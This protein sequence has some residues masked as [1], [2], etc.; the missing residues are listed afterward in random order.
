LVKTPIK[1]A[2]NK[3]CPEDF[4]DPALLTTK[5][6]GKTF[7]PHKEHE[8]PGEFGKVIFAERIVRPQAGIIDFSGFDPLL[9]RI[10][11]AI[12]DHT[13]RKGAAPMP[14]S[15]IPASP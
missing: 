7:N 9:T 12:D 11:A 2:D 8:A 6:D 14:A 15:L 5:I 1:G 13:K 3:S 4:F 10:E